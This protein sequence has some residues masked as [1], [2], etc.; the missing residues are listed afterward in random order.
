[1]KTNFF[2]IN[3][4]SK[5]S[6]SLES[7]TLSVHYRICPDVICVGGVCMS[8]ETKEYNYITRGYNQKGFVFQQFLFDAT[9]IVVN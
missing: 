4:L 2:F 9:Y 8:N 6:G 3:K 1:M 7:P 5:K